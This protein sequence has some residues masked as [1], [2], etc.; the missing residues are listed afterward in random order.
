VAIAATSASVLCCNCSLIGTSLSD[1]HETMKR[2]R[3]SCIILI[4]FEAD[5]ASLFMS[6]HMCFCSVPSTICTAHTKRFLCNT[7]TTY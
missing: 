5:N 6:Q 4:A 3:T 2:N 7:A 1:I